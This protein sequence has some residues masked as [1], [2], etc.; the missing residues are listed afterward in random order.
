MENESVGL[1]PPK[2]D[3][4]CDT[5]AGAAVKADLPRPK[6]PIGPIK[7]SAQISFP[8]E[9]KSRHGAPRSKARECQRRSPSSSDP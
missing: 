4:Q 3:S 9:H 6:T 5:T 8:K 1:K 7:K 2:P